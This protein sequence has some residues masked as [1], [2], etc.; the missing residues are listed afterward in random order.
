MIA[1]PRANAAAP[2]T[3]PFQGVLLDGSG[4]PK[5][6]GTYA[7][8]FR[9]FDV[10]TGGPILWKEGGK[11]VQVSGGHG[12]FS[13]TLG[14][15]TSFGSL[16]FDQPYW[17]EAQIPG[18]ASMTP[19]LPLQSA[20]YALGLALPFQGTA[21]VV[22]PNAALHIGNPST[23]DAIQGD[24]TDGYGVKGSSNTN[25]GVYGIS[26]TWE[27]VHGESTS[28]KGVYG[29]SDTWVGVWGRSNSSSGVRGESMTST[30]TEGQSVSGIG[31]SGI[32][33]TNTG[34]FGQSDS[35]PGAWGQ[36]TSNN[37]VVGQSA[38][39]NGVYGVSESDGQG[40]GENGV[41]GRANV[42]GKGGVYGEN[43]V[44]GGYGV[45]G[46]AIGPSGIGVYGSAVGSSDSR[47]VFGLAV[48]GYGVYG[49]ATGVQ[50]GGVRGVSG[51]GSSGEL[52]SYYN[53]TVQYS[54]G[55][56]FTLTD[57]GAGVYG[58]AGSAGSAAGVLGVGGGEYGL[59]NP[60]GVFI[61]NVI[62]TGSVLYGWTVPGSQP[63]NSRPAPMVLN[64]SVQGAEPLDV[65]SGNVTLDA[66]GKATV[67]LPDSAA[68][69]A[70]G[71][72]Y[73]LTSIGAPA[74]GVY[75]SEE[76]NNGH[77]RIAGGPAGGKISWM[78]TGTR[79]TP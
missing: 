16:S 36:S 54:S 24:S 74:A 33:S 28:D 32:S 34:V 15:P 4:A 38:T 43:P 71:V 22:A 42:T 35:Y 2:R 73:Q 1:L 21:S 10:P 40:H 44:S 12:A 79:Q 7:I 27:G 39:S 18:E 37:G 60:A 67:A 76:A 75:I 59:A 65:C 52:G 57:F 51:K 77:F 25:T 8:T 13:T 41:Y 17:L 47:G 66:D 9:L 70:A 23:G 72:R 78:V 14:D 26:A 50:G 62:V 6:D 61:G 20:P 5:P 3:I 46:K 63:A 69:W 58:S 30:G 48:D 53:G 29:V 64:Y 56:T 68:R 11:Q 19:R 55:D 45:S 31:V 49:A